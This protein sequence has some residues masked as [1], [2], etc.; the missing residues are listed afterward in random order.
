MY[1]NPDLLLDYNYSWR[2]TLNFFVPVALQFD[3]PFPN[4]L[5]ASVGVIHLR[6]K[7]LQ[8]MELNIAYFHFS[9]FINYPVQIR[10]I[11][12]FLEKS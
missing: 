12:F 10:N 6:N 1:S 3:Y 4:V 11:K 9:V 8:L 2:V 5:L 7:K